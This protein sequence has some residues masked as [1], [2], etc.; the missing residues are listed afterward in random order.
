MQPNPAFK[1]L[2][3]SDTDRLVILHTDDIGMCQASVQAFKDLWESGGISSG[4]IMMPCPWAKTAADYC[5]THPGVDMGV[6]ATLNAE[7]DTYRW[8]P[9]SSLDP[10]TGLVDSDGFLWRSVEEAQANA[11]PQAVAVELQ[12]QVNKALE[13]GVDVTHVD[14]HM[15]TVVHPKFI[16]AY[17]QAAMQA[18]LPVMVPA[19]HCMKWIWMP[20]LPKPSLPSSP[21][22]KVRVCRWWTTW[23]SCRSTGPKAR[24]KLPR[25]CS[26]SYLPVLPT[27]SSIRP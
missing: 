8:S 9:L 11:D 7:W 18:R 24:S 17:I 15:G 4:A 1:K 16:P 10:S 27:S 12:A 25:N 20:V 2:G 14:T 23:L 6:H 19:R 26:A 3:F 22:W 5:K 13:W 21:N